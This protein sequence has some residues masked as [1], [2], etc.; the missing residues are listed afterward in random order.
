MVMM[1]IIMIT[2]KMTRVTNE[3]IT[4]FRE[5]PEEFLPIVVVCS[6]SDSDTVDEYVDTTIEAVM[7]EEE[8]EEEKEGGEEEEGEEEKGEERE[9]A[10]ARV[11]EVM[12]GGGIVD[13]DGGHVKLP[14]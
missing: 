11:D 10:K 1:I 12:I 9:E 4:M 13:D 7:E 14:E 2:I 6:D 5:F 8:E 3:A